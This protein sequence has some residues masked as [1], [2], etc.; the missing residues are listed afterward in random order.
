MIKNFFSNEN[1]IEKIIEGIELEKKKLR[2][3]LFFTSKIENFKEISEKLSKKYIECEIIG[4]TTAGEV[5]NKAGIV[6]KSVTGIAF[7]ESIEY[8][9]SR[10]EDVKNL[11][12]LSRQQIIN[13]FNKKNYLKSKYTNKEV[14]ILFNEG[15]SG[16][17]ENV[18]S[19]INSI[20]KN[21]L[22]IIGGSGGDNCRFEK[23]FLSL[24]GELLNNT[25]LFLYLNF[26]KTNFKIKTYKDV[27][28]KKTDIKTRITKADFNNRIIYELDNKKASERYA[29]LLGINEN[30]L[31]KYLQ[32][33]PL[34]RTVLDDIYI[35]T[36]FSINA[37]KSIKMYTKIPE[38]I[39]VNILEKK[40]PLDSQK[41]VLENIKKDFKKVNMMFTVQCIL[42]ELNYRKNNIEKH[43]INNLANISD[44]SGFLSYGEQYK[45]IHLNQS[46]ILLCIGE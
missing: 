10:I 1:S 2:L 35:S 21:K 43:F 30:R 24:N 36:V 12:I 29:E 34:G 11:P 38:N 16:A 8:I 19:I 22:E 42:T 9:I 7:Y 20:F 23:T 15:L 39:T 28:Y 5:H 17:E 45:G 25:S 13:E 44:F 6:K 32:K 14:G 4:I 18:L 37:D 26:E 27:M 41:I 46:I 33:H 31:N 3:I 40:N